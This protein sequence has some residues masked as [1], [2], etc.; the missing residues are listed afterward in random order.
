M[1]DGMDEE[2]IEG[3]FNVFAAIAVAFMIAFVFMAALKAFIPI[4]PV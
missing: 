4:P 1:E 3:L 2:M